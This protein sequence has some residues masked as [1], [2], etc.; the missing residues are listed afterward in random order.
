LVPVLL[1]GPRLT[2]PAT[3]VTPGRRGC[4]RRRIAGCLGEELAEKF[5]RFVWCKYCFF[6]A[7]MKLKVA[8]FDVPL[9]LTIDGLGFVA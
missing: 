3:R 5:E 1:T 6:T 4:I 9:N 7:L 2:I 8:F